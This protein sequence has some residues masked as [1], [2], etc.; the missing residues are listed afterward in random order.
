M[1]DLFDLDTGKCSRDGAVLLRGRAL[2]VDQGLLAAIE[3]HCAQRRSGA[4]SR[5]AASRCRWR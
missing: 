5:P 4:W 3:E 2:A 1:T